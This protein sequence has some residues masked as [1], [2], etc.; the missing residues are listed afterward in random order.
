MSQGADS[1][2]LDC[3]TKAHAA[4][5]Q[6]LLAICSVDDNQASDFPSCSKP[7]PKACEGIASDA[8]RIAVVQMILYGW[9]CTAGSDIADDMVS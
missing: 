3:A 8:E 7:Y 4:T 6:R 5:R 1:G 9:L 2:K